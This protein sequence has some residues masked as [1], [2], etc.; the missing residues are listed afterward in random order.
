[1]S[2]VGTV[3]EPTI[4]LHGNPKHFVSTPSLFPKV[5]ME[6]E[7]F[8][9]TMRHYFIPYVNKKKEELQTTERA[10]LIVDEHSSRYDIE[11]FDLLNDVRI[12]LVIRL[13]HSSQWTQPMD[14][15]L[16]DILKRA[17]PHRVQ[18]RRS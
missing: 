1:V 7:T 2:A 4:L 15:N 17:F 8:K 14:L 10:V 18:E 9:L 11:T 6:R 13:A 12:D 5:K 3:V 16:N